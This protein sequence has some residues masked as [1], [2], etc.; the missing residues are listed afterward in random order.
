MRIIF[1][2]SGLG[3]EMGSE[4]AES[5]RIPQGLEGEV[6]VV[7]KSTP[8]QRLFFLITLICF[9]AILTDHNILTG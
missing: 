2:D 9:L 1:S 3:V 5:S 8:N 6:R 4:G 7:L